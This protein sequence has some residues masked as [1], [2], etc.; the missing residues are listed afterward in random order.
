VKTKITDL[1]FRYP[2]SN[3]KQ[4]SVLLLDDEPD[5]TAV[6][7]EGLEKQGPFTIHA[8][9]DP[10]QAL[11]SLSNTKY[12]LMLVDIRLPKMDGFEFCQKAQQ[13]TDSKVVFIT[14]SPKYHEEYQKRFPQWNGNCFVL[15]PISISILTE[16]LMSEL[17]GT[18]AERE[19]FN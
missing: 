1:S 18:R 12:D 11:K 2:Y 10:E 6:L 16:F 13:L 3:V 4:Y 15:K 14:A 7:K 9:N 5:V 17:L 8:Y 19:P